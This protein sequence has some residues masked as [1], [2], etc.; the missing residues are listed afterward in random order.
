MWFEDFQPGQRFCSQRRTVSEAD[1]TWF[2]AWSW[3]TNPVHTDAVG[4]AGGRF[5]T[6]IAHGLLGLSAAMG[7]ASRIGVFEGSSIA[8]LNVNDWEFHAPLR[9]GDTVR[10]D[11]EITDVRRTSSGK[12]GVLARTF[13]LLNQRDEVLQSG[14]IDLMVACRPTS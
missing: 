1:I 9:A 7:L 13:T 6:P 3:D 5:G 14:T 8:L 10:C 11:V 2:A 4:A 12:A